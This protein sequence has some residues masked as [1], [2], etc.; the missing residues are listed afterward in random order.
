MVSPHKYEKVPDRVKE[1]IVGSKKLDMFSEQFTKD[2]LSNPDAK[3]SGKMF[4]V[5]SITRVKQP[6]LA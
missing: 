2:I 5:I 3:M 1:I 6:T 4:S